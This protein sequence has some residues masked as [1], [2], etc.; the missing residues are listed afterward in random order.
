MEHPITDKMKLVRNLDTEKR[1]AIYLSERIDDQR[2]WYSDKTKA[3]LRSDNRFFAGIVVSQALAIISAFVIILWPRSQVN[4]TGIFTTLI[5]AFMA[6][7]Q[8]RQNEQLAQSY[9]LAA[10]EL[11]LIH[12]QAAEIKTDEE[13]SLYVINSENAISREHTMWLACVS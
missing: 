12:E 9:G 6:W 13:L 2:K 3:N 1:E 10:Q 5:T 7:T 11:H 4:F 8:M